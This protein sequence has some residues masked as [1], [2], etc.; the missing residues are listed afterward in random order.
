VPV[1]SR[2]RYSTYPERYLSPTKA[3]AK[4]AVDGG[5][6]ERVYDRCRRH[7]AVDTISPVREPTHQ[8]AQGALTRAG[9][10]CTTLST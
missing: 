8:K 4:L 9:P 1:V 7:S 10:N 2:A 5:G 6:I 3:A